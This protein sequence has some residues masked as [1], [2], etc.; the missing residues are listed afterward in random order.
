VL[1]LIGYLWDDRPG[2]AVQAVPGRGTR[3]PV[4]VLGSSLFGAE[5]AAQLGL[6]YAF[7][8]HF[9]PQALEQ[10]VAVYRRG[11]RP[12]AQLDAPR[13]MLALNVFAGESDAEGRFL[14]SSLEQAF[15]NLRAGRPGLLPR[16]VED[17]SAR[18]DPMVRAGVRAALACTAVG[19]PATVRRQLA[20]FID[21]YAPDE[22]I[23]TGQIHDPEARLRSFEIAAEALAALDPAPHPA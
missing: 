7:A 9:A 18:L 12:S 15:A 22:V 14:M 6:P 4:W 10:A 1:E 5:L 11:F 2:A 17:V 21:R 19:S 8:S 23:L 3:V 20:G 16:P 13:F